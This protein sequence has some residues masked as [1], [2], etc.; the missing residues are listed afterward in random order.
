LLHEELAM[1][2]LGDLLELM[3]GAAS[4]VG[5]V[6]ATLAERLRPRL[7]ERAFATFVERVDVARGGGYFHVPLGGVA[8][9]AEADEHVWRVELWAA[10]PDRFRQERS[11]PDAE[12][13]LVVDGERWWEWTPAFGLHTHEERDGV[14]HHGG[15][16]LLDPAA[17]LA[18]HDLEV[19]GE[20]AV[21]GRPATRV[22]VQS[23]DLARS[24]F[25]LQPGVETAEL[26][27]DSER[28][29]ILRLAELVD[30]EEALV[31][32]VEQIDYDQPP[33][34]GTF[35]FELPAGASA[36]GQAEPQPTTVDRAAALA[37]FTM[38]KL[39]EPPPGW[40][41]QAVYTGAAERPS[42]PD[43]VMLVYTRPDGAE[44]LQIRQGTRAHDLPMVGDRRRFDH[45]GRSYV[46]LGPDRP[47]GREPAELLFTT[48]G[49][50]VRLSCSQLSLEHLLEYADQLV[51]A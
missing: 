39:A 6:H 37:S 48:H 11:G 19:A 44:R 4:H 9:G 25:G 35:G 5:F 50:N 47:V 38:L 49:T 12:Q 10:P 45:N 3:H 30:G 8:P 22:R 33:P 2:E 46:A 7:L 32:E 24:P 21:A 13:V 51:V 36:R 26:L 29:L 18:G 34:E 23:T 27:L 14:R 28:G 42:L 20:G 16:D 43:S 17:F 40:H 1:S 15:L 31:R 41:V